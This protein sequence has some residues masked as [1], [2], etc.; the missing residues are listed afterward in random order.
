[1]AQGLTNLTQTDIGEGTI[2]IFP[3]AYS[4]ITQGTWALSV[5]TTYIHNYIYYNSS[6][7]IGDQIDYKLIL[8]AGDYTIALYGYQAAT[9]GAVNLSLDSVIFGTIDFYGAEAHGAWNVGFNVLTT[10][11]HTLSVTTKLG[12]GGNNNV[13]AYFFLIRRIK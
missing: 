4:S 13:F 8:S 7:A 10:G 9:L 5:T 1:M 2:L 3:W 12:H 11:I 6:N